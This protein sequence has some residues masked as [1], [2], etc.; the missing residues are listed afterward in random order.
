MEA[1]LLT[2]ATGVATNLISEGML[3]VPLLILL[4]QIRTMLKEYIQRRRLLDLHKDRLRK[5]HDRLR[6]LEKLVEAANMESLLLEEVRGLSDLISTAKKCHKE[7]DISA[8]EDAVEHL[9]DK[10]LARAHAQSAIS[11]V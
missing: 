5:V 7:L 8:V 6:K 3:A 1:I 11:L 4:Q 10:I 9:W 2:V